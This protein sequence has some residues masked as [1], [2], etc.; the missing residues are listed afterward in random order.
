MDRGLVEQTSLVN[1]NQEQRE[2]KLFPVGGSLVLRAWRE[3]AIISFNAVRHRE[4]AEVVQEKGRG[5]KFAEQQ[6]LRHGWEHG[7][8]L[9]RAENGISEA[10]KVKVKC[11]KGG[12]G[13]KEGEQF[14]F[15]WWDHVFNKAS[16]SLQVESDQNGIKL[17]EDD[18]GR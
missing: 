6:L 14:T 17:K 5:L 7:K 2:I 18:G 11:D 3:G 13:H 10:I 8:G 9:G 12:V 16:S 4:M 15:H 1:G